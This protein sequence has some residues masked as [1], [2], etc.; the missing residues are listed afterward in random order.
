MGVLEAYDFEYFL[1]LPQSLE[2]VEEWFEGHVAHEGT[3]CLHVYTFLLAVDPFC[4]NQGVVAYQPEHDLHAVIFHV[5]F[6]TV[7]DSFEAKFE[8]FVHFSSIF[9]SVFLDF[10]VDDDILGCEQEL[11]LFIFDFLGEEIIDFLVAEGATEEFL[12]DEGQLFGLVVVVGDEFGDE[13]DRLFQQF[14]Q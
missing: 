9:Y 6:V 10:F 4:D 3:N 7:Y 11:M 5:G 2:L 1:A 14:W 13:G 8:E 12:D